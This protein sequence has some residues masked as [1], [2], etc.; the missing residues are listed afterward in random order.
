M[1]WVNEM[2]SE[3]NKEC[4][5]PELSFVVFPCE[6]EWE[7]E[8]EWGWKGGGWKSRGKAAAATSAVRSAL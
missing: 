2:C 5:P 3:G 6:W 8:R 1:R 7:W 4:N